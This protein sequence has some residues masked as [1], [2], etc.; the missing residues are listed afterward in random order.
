MEIAHTRAKRVLLVD[1]EP[2]VLFAFRKIMETSGAG[3]D[4]AETREAAECLLAANTY[5]IIFS[6]MRLSHDEREG[7]VE[8]AKSVKSTSPGTKFVLMTAYGTADVELRASEAGVDM[9]LEHL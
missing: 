1:D 5:D 6:D 7:G 2:A 9:Y 4:T 3:V 8:L